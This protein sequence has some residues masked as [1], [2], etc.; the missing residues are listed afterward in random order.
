M[1]SR[2]RSDSEAIRHTLPLL[3]T[4]IAMMAVP[5][6][7]DLPWD[8]P[9]W[10]CLAVLARWAIQSRRIPAPSRLWLLLAAVT[11]VMLVYFHFHKF[12]GREAGVAL[13]L[14]GLGLKLLESRSLRDLYLVVYLT[15]FGAVTHYL[16]SQS[17]AV[18]AYTLCVLVLLVACLIR[19]NGGEILT[20]GTRLR[21]AGG[22]LAQA[23]P[24]TLVLFLFVPRV[25]GPLWKLPQDDRSGRTGL[26]DYLEPGAISRL[27]AT[28]ETAFRV[29]FEGE[30][31]P[32]RQRYWRGPVFWHFDGRRWTIGAEPS[33]N[34]QAEPARGEGKLYRYTVTLEPLQR[35]WVFPLEFPESVPTELTLLRDG[36]LLAAEPVGERRRFVLSSR[37]G[38]PSTI[39][40]TQERSRAL[41]LP[42]PPDP[43][44]RGLVTGWQGDRS[45]AELL[46]QRILDH[47]HT[48]PF[49]YT[50]RPPPLHGDPIA[51][52]LFETR[53]GFC[54]HF[55]S[56]FVYLMRVAGIPARIVTGYQGG[57]WNPVGKFLEIEQADAHA[58][59]EI[60]VEGRG[61]L[62]VDPTAAVAPERIER[63]LEF[64]GVGND[65]AVLFMDPVARTLDGSQWSVS[66][67]LRQA[68]WLWSAVDHAWTRWVLAYGPEVQMRFLRWLDITG[69]H[70]LVYWL[71]GLLSGLALVF[72][73]FFRPRQYLPTEPA[74]RLYRRVT[75]RLEQGGL[76]RHPAEGMRDFAFRVAAMR[77]DLAVPFG[78]FT[79]LFL[80]I[81][82]GRRHRADALQ[83]LRE[84]AKPLLA[85]GFLRRARRTADTRSVPDAAVVSARSMANR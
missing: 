45:S 14:V 28:R 71:G 83:R 68:D 39:L 16:F 56:T 41:Q 82:Y 78:R 70:H 69:W 1:N 33:H 50:L 57:H 2:P 52:F 46:A 20:P 27:G 25:T 80:E 31:P 32:P 3:G 54:E 77:P 60:W 79:E 21:L 64:A 18:F 19:L 10:V 34:V 73:G 37:P 13:F 63:E 51:G 59:A 72:L 9:A 36:Y 75:R 65:G 40:P 49:V 47:F 8:I 23:I 26:S 53:R 6:V 15:L 85:P 7:A 22:L 29:D 12:H 30:P 24:V 67:F 61:W 55:A 84:L 44:V 5:H 76:V 4:A 43:R 17:I 11:G 38:S 62:R 66:P 42:A 74:L 58:W 48:L 81:R 35:R